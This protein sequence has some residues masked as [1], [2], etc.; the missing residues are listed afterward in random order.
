MKQSLGAKTLAV[1]TPVWLVG[2]YDKAGKANIMAAAWGGICCSKPPCIQVSLR[3]ATFTHGNI[4]NRKSFTINIPDEEQWREADY[5][6]IVSGRDTDKIKDIGWMTTESK[7]VDAPIIEECR[8][9]IECRLKETIEL[10]LHTMFVGEI[11]DVKAEEASLVDGKLDITR[12]KPI[13]FNPG[14]DGYF[15]V[16]KKIADAFKQ[17]TPP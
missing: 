7:L 3:A 5:A 17:R 2:T 12:V 16:G 4:I 1:P 15:A 8:V 6:G 11:I 10:G 13:I 9:T 14:D